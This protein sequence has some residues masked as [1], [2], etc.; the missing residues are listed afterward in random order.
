[1]KLLE[2]FL[3]QVWPELSTRPVNRYDSPGAQPLAPPRFL[4]ASMRVWSIR[5]GDCAEKTRLP[6][7]SPAVG[8][9]TLAQRSAL[10]IPTYVRRSP[11]PDFTRSSD[12][13]AGKK[14]HEKGSTQRPLI[15]ASKAISLRV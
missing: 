9:H 7:S 13:L 12:W 1:M 14:R 4:A 2:A 10:E 5:P 11:S 15:R 8:S 6:S 3:P